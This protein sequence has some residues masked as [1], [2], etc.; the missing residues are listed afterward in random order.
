MGPVE[1]PTRTSLDNRFSSTNRTG[2]KAK[3]KTPPIFKGQY[4]ELNNVLNWI[5]T[6]ERYLF[7]CDVEE[8]M[9]SSFA[10]TYFGEVVQA[11]F[12][13]R[14]LTDPT[15]NWEL[16]TAALKDRYLP[17]DHIPRL[18]RKFQQ[19]RQLRSLMDYVDTYQV[20]ISA[21]ELSGV[22]KSQEELVRHF[23]DNLKHFEDRVA[24]L[25]HGVNSV[26]SCYKLANLLRGAKET[27]GGGDIARRKFN[28]LTGQAKKDA[29]KNDACLECGSKS[30][31]WKDCPKLAGKN[32]N[33]QRGGKK[34]PY[35]AAA[36]KGSSAKKN[37]KLAG[38]S[39][40]NSESE[41]STVAPTSDTEDITDTAET[42]TG[43]SSSENEDGD[44]LTGGSPP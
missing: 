3:L 24:M 28:R 38:K 8:N 2:S 15:P 20:M 43:T 14:F 26:E 5:I 44:L 35:S 13:N 34:K 7:N 18:L 33:L 21:L 1:R 9:Y 41:D 30:H 32:L 16:V 10:Y 37:Y 39:L 25:T 42:E 27:A 11:W 17:I 31:W 6:T 36:T 23:I 29:F 40:P 19:V 4:H 22:S 12:D